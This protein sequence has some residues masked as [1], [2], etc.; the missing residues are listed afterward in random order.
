MA[1]KINPRVSIGAEILMK[2]SVISQ[3]DTD[4]VIRFSA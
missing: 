2:L 4:K 3:Y 1:Q